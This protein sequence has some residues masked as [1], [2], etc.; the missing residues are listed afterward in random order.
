MADALP[1]SLEHLV[2]RLSTLPGVGRRTAERL[3]HHLVRA[4][5]AEALSIADAIRE[6]REKIRPCSVCR[7]PAESDPC[8]ICADPARDPALVLV[9]ETARDLKAVEDSGAW[10]GRYH[11]LG[12]RVSPI[13]GVGPDDLALDALVARATEGVREVVLATNPDLEGD[14]TALHVEKALAPTGV[15]VSRLARGV[16][17]GGS[18]EYLSKTV[19]AEALDHRR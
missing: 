9:V 17:A 7:A 11:V 15:K 1:K 2:E 12:G 8:P 5:Q 16:P 3:A 13:E 10:K 18:L 6:A 19:L 14:G 4:P